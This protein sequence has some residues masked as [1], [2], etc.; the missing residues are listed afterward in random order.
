MYGQSRDQGSDAS[1][2]ARS[3]PA[4]YPSTPPVHG[5]ESFSTD[6]KMKSVARGESSITREVPQVGSLLLAVYE[7]EQEYRAGILLVGE[8][9][10]I[11]AGR[12]GVCSSESGKVVHRTK[13]WSG[14]VAE[15]QLENDHSPGQ[16]LQWDE[17]IDLSSDKILYSEVLT[18]KLKSEHVV[19]CRSLVSR[20]K[21]IAK[22][23]E[24]SRGED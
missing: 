18:C 20:L 14:R 15:L 13:D 11:A 2:G 17:K 6:K 8:V 7:T 16:A 24:M 23:L 12:C 4:F 5:S 9:A 10:E 1:T 21:M 3:E 19:A 22:M